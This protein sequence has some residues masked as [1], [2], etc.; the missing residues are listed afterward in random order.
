MATVS[1]ILH[2]QRPRQDGSYPIRL[3]VTHKKERRYISLE[4]EDEIM[5]ATEEEWD[6]INSPKAKGRYRDMKLQIAVY[7]QKA[8]QILIDLAAQNKQFTFNRLEE[9]FLEKRKEG[10]VKEMFETVIEELKQEKRIGTAQS[11]GN[12]LNSIMVF[13]NKKAFSFPDVDLKFLKKYERHL[14]DKDLSIN[15]IGIYMRSLRTMYNR[16]IKEGLVKQADYPFTHYK[17]PAKAG[18]KRALTH[19]GMKRIYDY[20]AIPATPQW[21]AK[22]YFLFSY[23]TQGMNFTDMAHLK[24]SNIIEGRICYERQKTSRTVGEIT[25][26]SI[27]ITDQLANIMNQLRTDQRNPGDYLFP[28]LQKGLT[29]EQEKNKVRQFVKTTNKW[30]NRIGKELEFPL[31]LTTYVARHSYATVLKHKGYSTSTIMESLGH[32][33]EKTTQVYLDSLHESVLDEANENLL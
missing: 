32:K 14:R 16:A 18:R 2:K 8:K 9:Q 29:A 33:L 27:K 25:S 11:Y 15:T 6:K 20:P 10:T 21:Y 13:K 24:C 4:M 31:K 30:L 1:I 23:L 19:E 7:E 17:I 3:R 5:Y 22:N 28:I 26:F 12:A